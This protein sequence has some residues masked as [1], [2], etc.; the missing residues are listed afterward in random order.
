[1]SPGVTD[2]PPLSEFIQR[3]V[4]VTVT[5]HRG[6]GSGFFVFPFVPD[7][8]AV[9][10]GDI[11]DVPLYV[12]GPNVGHFRGR[13]QI[14]RLVCQASDRACINS[15]EGQRRGYVAEVPPSP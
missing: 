3:Y 13:P 9:S 5:V 12:G 15:P 1:M 11:V 8:M 4:K 2:V 10:I 14:S 6:I 7:S